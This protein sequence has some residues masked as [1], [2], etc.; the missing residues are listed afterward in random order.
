M[1]HKDF[2]VSERIKEVT[3]M[4][5][6]EHAIYERISCFGIALY[7][8]G[9]FEEDDIMTVE[10]IETDEAAIILADN[11]TEI[12]KEAIP[13]DYHIVNSEEK[14]LVMIGEPLFPK[15]FAVLVDSNASKPFFSKMRYFGSGFDSLNDLMGSFLGEDGLSFDDIHYFR[16]NIEKAHVISLQSKIYIVKEND[17]RVVCG[18]N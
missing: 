9:L 14:Y 6:R 5:G 16:K 18:Y 17:E 13:S 10:D 3:K 4:C 8:L 2:L 1:D 15:H 7:V 12:K 11:F